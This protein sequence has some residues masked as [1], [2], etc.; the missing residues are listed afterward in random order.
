[1]FRY[2]LLFLLAF[3][4]GLLCAQET[5]TAFSPE[6]FEE[7]TLNYKP[8]QRVGVSEKDY[9]FGKMVL[10]ETIRQTGDDA[11]A[12]NLAD[13]FNVLSAFLTLREP[14]PALQLAFDKF[15]RAPGSC[16]YLIEFWDKV[17]SSPKYA[18]VRK[19]WE[20]AKLKCENGGVPAIEESSLEAYGKAN[21][22]ELNLLR[23]I[24]KVD[25]QDQRFRKGTYNPTL[26]IPLDRENER[27]I[28]SLYVVHGQYIGSDLVGERFASVMWSVIQHS[29]LATMERYLPVLKRAVGDEQLAE[30]PLRMLID[31]VYTAKT[32][33]QVFGSQQGGELLP[34]AERE[35]ICLK[36]GI[37]PLIG[38]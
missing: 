17:K 19:D 11:A 22:L 15:L 26:Q 4:T 31:R 25:N 1:M 12:F 28:D 5:R 20:E 23:V 16:E 37:D 33:R 6:N 27:I 21:F 3:L 32:G 8:P 7:E 14:E 34:P 29:R 10:R 35:R 38:R 13:Y 30:T 36:Y 18:P 24:E 2:L 9:N